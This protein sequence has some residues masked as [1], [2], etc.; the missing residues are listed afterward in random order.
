[1]FHYIVIFNFS[2]CNHTLI[3]KKYEFLCFVG[4]DHMT[5]FVT[6]LNGAEMTRWSITNDS[7]HLPTKLPAGVDGTTYFIYYSYGIKPDRPWH[8][9]VDIKVFH[10]I[11]INID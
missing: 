1:M 7:N 4:P 2:V 5:I 6:P 8:F 9:F 3:L 11:Y 10:H